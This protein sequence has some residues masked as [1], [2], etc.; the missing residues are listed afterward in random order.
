MAARVALVV[1]IA[2]AQAAAAETRPSLGGRAVASLPSAPG[3]FDPVE[4]RS[5]ADVLLAGLVFDGL[6]RHDA[7]G[8]VVPH[9]A[10]SLP[11]LSADGLE[12]R[13]ALRAGVRFHDGRPVRPADVSAS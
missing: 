8:R 6:Y 1:L 10:E 7:A 5:A 13:I 11:A 2:L 3:T 12:A 9:L 4:A